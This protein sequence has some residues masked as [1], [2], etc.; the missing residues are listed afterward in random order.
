MILILGGTTEG[1]I[2]A[3]VADEAGKTYYYSTKGTMQ[4]IVSRHGIRVT[5][6]MDEDEMTA[7]CQKNGIRLMVDAAHPLP[8]VFMPRLPK[9]G[10]YFTCRLYVW[11]EYIL[12]A[13]MI[14]YGVKIMKM[15]SASWRK[16]E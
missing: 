11:N 6:G 14:L 7:C 10:S 12:H 4:E 1:R 15:Q 16:E 3:K 9:S 13:L 5:G 2:A 8:F